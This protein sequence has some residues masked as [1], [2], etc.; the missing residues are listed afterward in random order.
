[1]VGDNNQ[2]GIRITIR[3]VATEKTYLLVQLLEPLV[4]KDDEPSII[5]AGFFIN[6]LWVFIARM[7][8]EQ[9]RMQQ[10]EKETSIFPKLDSEHKDVRA[11]LDVAQR[12]LAVPRKR[13]GATPD[14]DNEWARERI[15]AGDNRQAVY[16][17]WLQRKNSDDTP[18]SKDAFRQALKRKVKGRT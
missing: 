16:K 5:I 2:P 3:A 15:A 13:P 9:E 10:L 1:M 14:P 18:Q 17:E 6:S 8:E 7:I 12:E 11:A 4:D